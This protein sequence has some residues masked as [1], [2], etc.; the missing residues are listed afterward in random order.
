[1]AKAWCRQAS[2][3]TF[4]PNARFVRHLFT[5]LESQTDENLFYKSVSVIKTL[6]KTSKYV[7][8]L[9]HST[10]TEVMS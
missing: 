5:I 8:A 9:D 2:S 6:L 10:E 1:M 7:R 4:I 3:Q